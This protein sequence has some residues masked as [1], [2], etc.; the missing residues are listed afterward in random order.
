MISIQGKGV[1]AGVAMGPLYY[2]Q[3]A[4]S[5]IRR[6]QVEDTAAEW[7]RFKA[8]QAEAIAQL[9]GCASGARLIPYSSVGVPAGLLAAFRPDALTAGDASLPLLVAVSPTPVSSE[10]DY[11]ILLPSDP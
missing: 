5:T 3:R 2:Y 4:K 10:G 6:V 9:R 1:S 7:E 8:A 11:Q